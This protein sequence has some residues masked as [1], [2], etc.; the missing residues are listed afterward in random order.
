L[1]GLRH[2]QT[3]S[4]GEDPEDVGRRLLETLEQGVEGLAGQHMDLV[5]DENPVTI[6]GRTELEELAKLPDIVNAA[7]RRA[8]DLD[9]IDARALRHLETGNAGS[10][11]LGRRTLDAVDGLGQQTGSRRLADTSQSREQIGVTEGAR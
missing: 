4:G 5:N 9:D 3:F 7:V 1:N 10:A 2:L 6:P 11:R 8:V